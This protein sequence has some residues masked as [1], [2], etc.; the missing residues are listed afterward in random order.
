MTVVS[1]AS[2]LHYLVLI[3]AEHVLAELFSEVVSSRRRRI[4]CRWS[5]H[6]L[7]SSKPLSGFAHHFWPLSSP[8]TNIVAP[9]AHSAAS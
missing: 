7:R 8:T 5:S 9:E 4:C 3:K 2:P 6:S 1:D